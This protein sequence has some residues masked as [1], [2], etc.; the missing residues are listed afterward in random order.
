MTLQA[1]FVE[2]GVGLTFGWAARS[3]LENA[4]HRREE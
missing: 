3:N 1:N 2:Q 4:C